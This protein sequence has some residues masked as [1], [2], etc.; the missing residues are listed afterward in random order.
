[1]GDF[2]L[3]LAKG[4]NMGSTTAL[5]GPVTQPVCLSLRFLL[6]AMGIITAPISHRL[7]WGLSETMLGKPR[8]AVLG[9]C[10]DISRVSERK[11]QAHGS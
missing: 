8:A 3:G 6:C 10:N 4:S 2:G 7:L 9:T 1:M 5:L 11:R